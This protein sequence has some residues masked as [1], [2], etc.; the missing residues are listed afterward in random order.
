MKSEI[1][2]SL[3][4]FLLGYEK[5]VEIGKL[6]KK[7]EDQI[8][9]AQRAYVSTVILCMLKISGIP[10]KEKNEMLEKIKVMM[11]K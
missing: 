10:L 8:E 3:K 7:S 4:F 5:V 11:S 2:D 1:A 6:K 9:F